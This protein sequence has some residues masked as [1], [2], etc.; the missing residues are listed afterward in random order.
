MLGT[1]SLTRVMTVSLGLVAVTAIAGLILVGLANYEQQVQIR[2]VRLQSRAAQAVGALQFLGDAPRQAEWSEIAPRLMREAGIELETGSI[3]VMIPAPDA[4]SKWRLIAALPERPEAILP[5]SDPNVQR[6]LAGN[7]EPVLWYDPAGTQ[8]CSAIMPVRDRQGRQVALVEARAH[9]VIL[10]ESEVWWALGLLASGVSIATMA[11]IRAIRGTQA[12]VANLSQRLHEVSRGD[13][14]PFVTHVAHPRELGPLAGSLQLATEESTIRRLRQHRDVTDLRVQVARF[15]GADRAKTTL[16]VALC[17]SLRQSVDSLRASS[18]LLAQTRIDRVQRDYVETLQSGC[19]DLLTR[20][21]DVLDFA[22]LE[23]ECLSLEQRPL[24]P[25]LVL[26]EALLIVAERC[27]QLPIELA[28][29]AEPHVPERVI[30]DVARVRQVLVNLVSLAASTAEEG[31]VAVHVVSEPDQRLTFRISLMGVTLTAERIRLLLEGAISTESSSDRLQGEGLGLVLGKR[32]AQAM[33]G[34]LRIER[35]DGEDIELVC[36]LRVMP[37]DVAP[38]QP[39]LRRTVVVAHERPATRRML[40]SILE[41]AGATVVAVGDH[42]DLLTALKNGLRPAVVILGTRVA[43]EHDSGSDA[44]E[45]IAGVQSLA[46]AWP[47]ILVVDPVHRGFTPELRSAGAMGLVAMPVRQQ[48]LLTNV[49][50]AVS[51]I[52]RISNPQPTESLAANEHKV[53][54]AEDNDVNRLVLVRMLESLGI[55]P[56]LVMNGQQAVDQVHAARVAGKPYALILMDCMMPVVDGLT[57]TQQIRATQDSDPHE[58]IIAVTAN[59]MAHD[60]SQCLA[61]GMDDYLAK[62]VTPLALHEAIGRWRHA[63]GLPRKNS[64]RLVLDAVTGVA[65]PVLSEMVQPHPKHHRID[66]ENSTEIGSESGAITAEVDFSGLKMLAKLAGGGAL[67]EVVSCFLGE[68]EKLLNDVHS[69]AMAGD[70]TRLRA[71]AH[72]MKGSCGTVGLLATQAHIARIESA[73]KDGDLSAARI[74]VETLPSLFAASM[75]QL[76]AFRDGC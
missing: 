25:R 3:E 36:T 41:R 38:E 4:P 58:W 48:A 63:A 20:I 35:G 49:C 47:V 9:A 15:Q 53:L 55:H 7:H 65:H 1:S 54:V 22:L 2:N 11:L 51:G 45:V 71:V 72:K 40:T 21:G 18:A 75:V 42:G 67:I 73:A 14:S 39:L 61:A 24:R 44:P 34:S 17:R 70:L 69:A 19:G 56:E 13:E 57:A 50:D 10:V 31:T 28:W 27:V 76:R 37:D 64:Q 62:P 59:A 66:L 23:A 26:E 52:K 8:W 30:G 29:F 43:P 5:I 33:G 60:R 46:A 68:S 32:L 12:A 74:H 16:L 6:A